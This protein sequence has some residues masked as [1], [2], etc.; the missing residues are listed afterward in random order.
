MLHNNIQESTLVLLNEMVDKMNHTS[1]IKEDPISIPHRFTKKQDVEIAGFFAAIFAWGNRKTIINKAS[2]LIEFMDNDPHSFILYHD[3][4]DLKRYE[5]FTHRTFQSTDALYFIEFLKHHY[6]HFESLEDAFLPETD[7]VNGQKS[8]LSHFHN[9]FF[10]LPFA[11]Q[12]TKKHVSSPVNNST[13]KRLNMYFRW[14]VRKDDRGVD[15]GLWKRIPTSELMIPYDVH[16]EKAAR[17]LG[18]LHRK[19]RDWKAVEELTANLRLL[20]PFDPIKYDY[21]LFGLSIEKMI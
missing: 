15:F 9:Y 16:V 12:R 18:L 7:F 1:F 5:N 21:A 20:D 10:S 8:R 4:K 6:Q 3:E 17:K 13:C 14:M 2:E 11:P 19:Q